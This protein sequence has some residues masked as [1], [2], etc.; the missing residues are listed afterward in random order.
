MPN[1]K[2]VVVSKRNETPKIKTKKPKTKTPKTKN[3]K[4][5]TKKIEYNYIYL[6]QTHHSI[7]MQ[8]NVYKIGKTTQQNIQRIRSYPKCSKL[9]LHMECNDCHE[10]ERILLTKFKT[11]FNQIKKYGNEY[12]EGNCE[13]MKKIIIDHIIYNTEYQI[14]PPERKGFFHTITHWFRK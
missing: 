13:D 10:S 14:S 5:K 11:E 12:F 2:W 7:D 1:K 6:L 8:E 3:A 9:L 4:L